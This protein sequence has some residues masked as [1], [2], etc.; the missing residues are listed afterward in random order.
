MQDVVDLLRLYCILHPKTEL[1]FQAKDQ[2]AVQ[3]LKVC[4]INLCI[5][6]DVIS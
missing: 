1:A 6:F 5:Y 2:D 4:T 3:L